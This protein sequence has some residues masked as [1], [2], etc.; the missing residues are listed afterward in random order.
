MPSR[1]LLSAPSCPLQAAIRRLRLPSRPLRA[2][3]RPL[4]ASS[5]RLRVTSRRLRAPSCPLRAPWTRRLSD[6]IGDGSVEN[7][8]AAW[9]GWRARRGS[10]AAGSVFWRFRKIGLCGL[11]R[12][13]W[14]YSPNAVVH[15]R[16]FG[17]QFG[18][19]GGSAAVECRRWLILPR[20]PAPIRPKANGRT[21]TAFV[22]LRTVV[23]SRRSS[24][25]GQAA[26]RR[27]SITHITN[28]P[29]TRAAAWTRRYPRGRTMTSLRAATDELMHWQAS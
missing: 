20:P 17:G 26:A 10:K 21:C 25:G 18:R 2:P 5:P 9:R 28:P 8:G 1:R 6:V 13:G 27:R 4:D 15:R 11:S 12:V 14:A 7:A 24:A 16:A 19:N 22:S 3:S 23:T 29:T